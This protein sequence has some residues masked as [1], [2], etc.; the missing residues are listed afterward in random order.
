MH[1]SSPS[2]EKNT[3]AV[4]CRIS[5]RFVIRFTLD[6]NTAQSSRTHPLSRSRIRPFR[7]VLASSEISATTDT[8]C[9]LQPRVAGITRKLPTIPRRRRGAKRERDSPRA[10]LLEAYRSGW[11]RFWPS[12]RAAKRPRL[13]A[14]SLGRPRLRCCEEYGCHRTRDCPSAHAPLPAQP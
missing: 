8:V 2:S 1:D 9:Y 11:G 4:F 10:R 12:N 13:Q 14:S 3:R 7:R 6:Y 5:E